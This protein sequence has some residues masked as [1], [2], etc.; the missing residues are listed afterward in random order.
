MIENVASFIFLEAFNLFDG[1]IEL[2]SLT[3]LRDDVEIVVIFEKLVH[4]DD[5]GVILSE[6]KSTHYL[7]MSN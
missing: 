2:G 7:R 6:L 1:V 4:F 5:I 3:K